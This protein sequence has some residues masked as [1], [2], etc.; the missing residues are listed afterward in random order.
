[1]LHSSV[2]PAP[3]PFAPYQVLFERRRECCRFVGFRSLVVAFL[4][5]LFERRRECCRFVDFRSLVVAFLKYFLNGGG[6]AAD[7]WTSVVLSL[8]FSS[9]F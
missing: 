6:N 1:M 9:T 8:L 2:H 7:S 4:Q 5:V 3:V